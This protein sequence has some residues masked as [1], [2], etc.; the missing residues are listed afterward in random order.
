MRS[1][2]SR[3]PRRL[4]TVGFV[5]SALWASPSVALD[6]ARLPSQLA[7]D[8]YGVRD[9]IPDGQVLSLRQ[10]EDG[11]LWIGMSCCVLRYD[12][13]TF[14]VISDGVLETNVFGHVRDFAKGARGSLF[15]AAAGGLLE[16]QEGAMTLRSEAEGL[17]HPFVYSLL[18]LPHGLLVGT[19]GEGLFLFAEGRFTRLEPRSRVRLPAHIHRIVRHKSGPIWIAGDDSLF[20]LSADLSELEAVPL[21]AGRGVRSLALTPSGRLLVGGTFGVLERKNDGR[22]VERVRNLR[23]EVMLEDRD[24]LLWI[25]TEV[26]L[27]RAQNGRLE[28]VQ[29]ISTGVRALLEDERGAIWVGTGAG[30]ERYRDGTFVTW[31]EAEG[32]TPQNILALEPSEDGTLW[33]VDVEGAIHR[34]RPGAFERFEPPGTVSGQGMLSMT[35]PRGGGLL[36]AA[37]SLLEIP[38]SGRAATARAPGPFS[39]A[40][41]DRSSTL[42]AQTDPDGKSRLFTYQK[43]ALSPFDLPEPVEHIQRVFRDKRGRLWI[44]SGGG[45]L[46]RV[47]KKKEV[48]RFRREQGL[49]SDTVYGIAEDAEGRIWVGTREGLGFIEDDRAQSLAHLSC[50]PRRSPV[51]LAFDRY[52]ALWVSADDGIYRIP[53]QELLRALREGSLSCTGRAFMRRDGLRSLVVSW[54]PGGLAELSDGTLCFAT[55]AGLSCTKPKEEYGPKGAPL[56]RIEHVRIGGRAREGSGRRVRA[57]DRRAPV[58]LNYSAV[59]LS[60]PELLEFQTRLAGFDSWSPVT[61][62]RSV[63]YTNLP[64]GQFTFE[65]RARY[66]GQQWSSHVAR[67]AL[68]VEPAWYETTLARVL[69]ALLPLALGLSG[70]GIFRYRNRK[71]RRELEAG[72]RARTRELAAQIEENRRVE[73]ELRELANDLDRHVR[74][75]TAEL[76]IANRALRRSEERYELAVS[77]AEDGIWDWD[78]AAGVLYLSLRWKQ[79]LGYD[80]SFPS[81]IDAWLS[82]TH[83]D[84]RAMLRAVLVSAGEKGGNIRCEYRMLN[85]DDQIVWVQ[86]RGV[87]VSGPRG[88]IRAAGSQTDITERK[89]NENELLKRVT[90]D[91]LTGLPNRSLFVDRLEQ[92]LRREQ[93]KLTIILINV[94]RL[95]AINETRGLGV[96][97][98]VLQTVAQRA[99]EVLRD[100]DTLAR[101]GS[102][103][104][105]LLLTDVPDE[106]AAKGI[107][108]RIREGLLMPASFGHTS[109]AISLSFGVKITEPQKETAETFLADAYLALEDAKARGGGRVS[110]FTSELGLEHQDRL[111]IEGALRRALRESQFVLHYQPLVDLKTGR[112]AGVE[113]LI[114]WQDP[115]RGLVGPGQFIAR[116]EACGLI[117]PISDWVLGEACRQARAWQLQLGFPVKVSINIAPALLHGHGLADNILNE[118]KRHELDPSSL[119]LEIVESSILELNQEVTDTLNRLHEKGVGISIDDFGTGYSSLAYLSRLPITALKLDRSL[120]ERVP[121]DPTDSAICKSMVEMAER[122]GIVSVVE[123]VETQAQ[124][125]YLRSIGC[126]LAQG[127]YFSKPLAAIDAGAYLSLVAKVNEP[128]A[129]GQDGR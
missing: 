98:F 110:V 92:A 7:H 15:S 127:Y 48:R 120:V 112:A 102:D 95:K 19:G 99:A 65:V 103:E 35:E 108:D 88:P 106:A 82:R 24:G 80:D 73:A 33:M 124:V 78:I 58:Q 39:L 116:A 94:D 27:Y 56:P 2:L 121:S 115:M 46:L 60:D 13:E 6:P 11:S 90:H 100:T 123:G 17:S 62:A 50:T 51:H 25:G 28:L 113:A 5:V 125:D 105:A 85:R 86:C 83:P 41:A 69:G 96:G 8:S 117:A 30:L 63:T 40:F 34:G 76:E 49:P 45:G 53:R 29:R 66:Q 44:S 12:G 84:D 128:T 23:P 14:E 22:F 70:F 71:Y 32:L 36:L 109:Q 43:G 16:I 72:V 64:A 10:A 61:R 38:K 20:Q 79:M 107:V 111:N 37:D 68:V 55:E 31:G 87:V 67:T 126:R 77:G 1:R 101:L 26:G 119:T 122:L 57:E 54:R 4:F 42:V 59:E 104:F 3:S 47:E 75:R 118:L 21:P 93:G 18:A 74:A 97:D 129:E 52:D 89:A 114:R 91:P 9:G 81:T